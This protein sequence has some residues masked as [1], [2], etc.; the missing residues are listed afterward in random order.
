MIT[1]IVAAVVALVLLPVAVGLIAR[2]FDDGGPD[3]YGIGS[4]IGGLA[5]LAIVSV[6]LGVW[7]LVEILVWLWRHVHV[8][9]GGT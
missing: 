5:A 6:P 1:W 4:A 2:L 7:K 8:S 3:T 9:L